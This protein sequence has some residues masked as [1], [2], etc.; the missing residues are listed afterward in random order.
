MATKRKISKKE[1]LAYPVLE[2]I[3]G[4]AKNGYRTK[5]GDW[6]QMYSTYSGA[7]GYRRV[8]S[9]LIKPY[10]LNY[11]DFAKFLQAMPE[12]KEVFEEMAKQCEIAH[13]AINIFDSLR[14]KFVE[15]IKSKFVNPNA[16]FETEYIV[17]S[18]EEEAI[19][20]ELKGNTDKINALKARAI[21]LQ[22][23]LEGLPKDRASA[24]LR[25]TVKDELEE[26]TK[27]LK[28]IGEI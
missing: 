25:K 19:C 23:K 1:E 7:F 14:E 10:Q 6:Y 4:G 21:E 2:E 24:P 16:N 18:D 17:M 22:E 9:R 28:L 3:T 15:D 27:N 12:Y 11:G 5:S 26:I 8:W 13:N 20:N